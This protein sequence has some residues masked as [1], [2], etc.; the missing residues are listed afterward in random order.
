MAAVTAALIKELRDR[1]GAGMG[2]C[3]KALEAVEG[4]LE[5]GRVAPHGSPDAIIEFL[6]ER[7]VHLV[8]WSDWEVLDAHERALGEARGRER[9]KVVPREDMIRIARREDDATA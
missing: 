6:T 2:D 5:G 3:K 8:Q 1:T 7:G 4:D 9:V